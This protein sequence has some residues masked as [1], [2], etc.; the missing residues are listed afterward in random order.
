SFVVVPRGAETV[1]WDGA[2]R[3]AL[4]AAN[5]VAIDARMT[6]I[7][8]ARGREISLWDRASGARRWSVTLASDSLQLR[9]AGD[10][11]IVLDRRHR[12]HRVGA[13]GDTAIATAGD[14]LRMDAGDDG[15]IALSER[16][17]LELWSGRAH[18]LERFAR[19]IPSIFAVLSADGST[20]AVPSGDETIR[21]YDCTDGHPVGGLASA[22]G[23]VERLR[24][25]NDGTRILSTANDRALRIWDVPHRRLIVRLLGASSGYS[26]T[27]FDP[28]GTR[29]AAAGRDGSIRVFAARE[30]S[31]LL[32]VDAGE[33]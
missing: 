9:F 19:P 30:P 24:F 14:V 11:V 8:L 31:L 18:R 17:D 3:G 23:T 15:S 20:L 6:S 22:Q 4:P 26:Q 25:S 27:A 32:D 10:D 33:P 21:L 1:I 16:R 5:Q 2:R 28:D 13:D 29:V 12:V 7:A